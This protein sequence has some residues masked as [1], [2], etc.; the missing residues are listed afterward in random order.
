MRHTLLV[1]LKALTVKFKEGG[2]NILNVGGPI[3]G[4]W[5]PGKIEGEEGTCELSASISDP[6]RCKPRSTMPFLPWWTV[7]SNYETKQALPS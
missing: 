2:K 6:I 4:D 5:D 3:P 1:S 7:T